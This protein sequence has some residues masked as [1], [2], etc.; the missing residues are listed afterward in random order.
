MGVA[1][2][3]GDVRVGQVDGHPCSR[4]SSRWRSMTQI[5]FSLIS[6]ASRQFRIP[7]CGSPVRLTSGS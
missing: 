2:V 4:A 5:H 3:E 1:V 6:Q 7:S